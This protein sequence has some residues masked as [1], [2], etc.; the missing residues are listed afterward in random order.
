MRIVE[1]SR[2]WVIASAL[3]VVI[4]W[5]LIGLVSIVESST[6]DFPFQPG[7][8]L[9]YKLRWGLI[10]A[11]S[12]ELEV[13]PLAQ[14]NGEGAWHFILKVRTSDF[15]DLFYKVR[16]RIE[17]YTDLVLNNSMLY[18]KE[19]REGS[20][21]RDVLVSFD[22]VAGSAVYSNKGAGHNAIAIKA[23]TIDPLASIYFIR[24]QFLAE[25][26][27][28]IKPVTDGKKVVLGVV[29]V[30]GRETLAING[31]EYDTFLVEPDMKDVR[32]VFEKSRKSKLKL[33]FTNDDRRLLVKVKSKVVVGSFTATLVGSTGTL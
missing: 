27:E 13:L 23:G 26:L 32:G 31:I 20:T 7:E 17:S 25:N 15:V 14:I 11:G 3:V 33:W 10:P 30:V 2:L 9:V 4:L 5:Q 22:R 16:D 19:Q 28:I 12:A 6:A 21:D 29:R 18:R 8:R 24:N 1:K